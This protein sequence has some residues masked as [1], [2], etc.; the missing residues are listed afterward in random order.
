MALRKHRAGEFTIEQVRDLVPLR[1]ILDLCGMVTEGIE[2]PAGCYLMAYVGDGAV[3]AVGV[4]CR[5]DAALMRS[6]CVAEP[7]RRRGF[8]DRLI[9]AARKA[10]HTRGARTLYLLAYPQMAGYFG[11][12]GFVQTDK[13]AMMSAMR[14]APEVEYYRARPGEL[15]GEIAMALDISRDGVI[16]R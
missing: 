15:A 8:G 5:L 14:G 1:A 9:A 4:E 3:G 12:F 2:W 11:R 16:E 13:D 10:A 6:L 7:H